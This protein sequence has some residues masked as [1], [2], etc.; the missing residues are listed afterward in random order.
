MIHCPAKCLF[1]WTEDRSSMLLNWVVLPKRDVP[2]GAGQAGVSKKQI[3]K[4]IL[5]CPTDVGD[6]GFQVV[7]G[8]LMTTH[9][10]MIPGHVGCCQA[11]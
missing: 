6:S 9:Q 7:M 4:M 2:V 11:K 3:E 8:W 1:Q 5:C 10:N